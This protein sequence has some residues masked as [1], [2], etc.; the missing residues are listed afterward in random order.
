MQQRPLSGN[1]GVEQRKVQQPVPLCSV[2]KKIFQGLGLP[3]K[4]IDNTVREGLTTITPITPTMRRRC[5]PGNFIT[6]MWSI[7]Y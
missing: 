5:V 1:Q 7:A 3:R 4:S 2:F 6:K